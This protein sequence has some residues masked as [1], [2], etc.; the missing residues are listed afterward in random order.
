MSINEK[1]DYFVQTFVLGL[2]FLGGAFCAV[3]VDPDPASIGIQ[4]LTTLNA[5]YP[6]SNTSTWVFY[7]IV[8]S[9][10]STAVT[11]IAAYQMRGRLG[12]ICIGL[13]WVGGFVIVKYPTNTAFVQFGVI[14]VII[15]VILGRSSVN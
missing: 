4:I 11:L 7:L 13:A 9:I 3:G 8:A 1:E 12:S 2:G 14:L 10:I 5:I 15:G 6:N